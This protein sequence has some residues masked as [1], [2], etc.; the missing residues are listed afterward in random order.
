MR[1][2]RIIILLATLIGGNAVDPRAITAGVPR[3]HYSTDFE[4]SVGPEWVPDS[5]TDVT[6]KGAR[7]FLGQ[8]G[9]ERVTLTLD[10]LPGHGYVTVKF[11][12]FI[13][14]SWDG[15]YVSPTAGP[16][17]RD[18]SAQDGQTVLHTTFN[19]HTFAEQWQAYPDAYPGGQHASNTGAVEVNSL[20]YSCVGSCTDAVCRIQS[21]VV[22]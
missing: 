22:P 4:G 6:P 19:T 3:L 2:R 8:F 13:I 10:S 14:G 18:L 16:D 1:A 11:D 12:L 7:G 17:I 21:V 15:N 5:R 20:G 9:P